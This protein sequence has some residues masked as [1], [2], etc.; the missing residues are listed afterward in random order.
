MRYAAL[1]IIV[2]VIYS[3]MRQFHRF[4]KR[5]CIFAIAEL[6]TNKQFLFKNRQQWLKRSSREA[7][8]TGLNLARDIFSSFFAVYL[9]VALL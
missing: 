2:F 4:A 6:A 7:Q 8:A 5:L 3:K 1:R 9:N